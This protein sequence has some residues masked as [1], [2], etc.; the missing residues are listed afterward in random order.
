VCG[1]VDLF[2][3]LNLL[4][5]PS[6]GFLSPPILILISFRGPTAEAPHDIRALRTYD[7]PQNSEKQRKILLCPLDSLTISRSTVF[8]FRKKVYKGL[9]PFGMK[10]LNQYQISV[11]KCRI[12]ESY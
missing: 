7:P 12:F 4:I 6:V 10:Q 11:E 5:N 8:T 3:L 9:T 1:P 2:V